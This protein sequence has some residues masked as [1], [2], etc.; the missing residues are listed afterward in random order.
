MG[1]S[2]STNEMID[3]KKS[4]SWPS[5]GVRMQ[6]IY[7]WTDVEC[8]VLYQRDAHMTCLIICKYIN[9]NKNINIDM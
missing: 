1:T 6:N 9:M 7:S 5:K 2:H 4:S 3:Q 8:V